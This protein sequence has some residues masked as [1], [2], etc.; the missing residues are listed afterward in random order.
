MGLGLGLGAASW[1]PPGFQNPSRPPVHQT[2]T[3]LNP[4]LGGPHPLVGM[5]PQVLTLRWQLVNPF[6]RLIFVAMILLSGA[7]VA[8]F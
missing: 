1:A 5:C 7:P 3:I 8:A 4:V 2:L 6:S